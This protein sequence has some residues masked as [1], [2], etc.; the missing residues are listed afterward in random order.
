MKI[1]LST[2]LLLLALSPLANAKNHQAVKVVK[3]S[4]AHKYQVV[5]QPKYVKT[6]TVIVSK[7]KPKTGVI[8]GG[9]VGGII[10]HNASS[11][12][13]KVL[14]TVTGVIIGSTIGNQVDYLTNSHNTNVYKKRAHNRYRH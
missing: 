1:L 2:T 4:P 9:L 12:S 14:G 6:K 10:G 7:T 3:T 11:D 5:K 13:N 8:I